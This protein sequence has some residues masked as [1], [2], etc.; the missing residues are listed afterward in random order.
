MTRRLALAAASVAV[1]LATAACGGG[2]SDRALPR[3][4]D[5]VTGARVNAATLTNRTVGNG[6]VTTHVLL[7]RDGKTVAFGNNSTNL[8]GGPSPLGGAELRAYR[9]LLP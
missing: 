1:V 9:K 2:T 7:S 8:L 4:V 3:V 5:L 6:N